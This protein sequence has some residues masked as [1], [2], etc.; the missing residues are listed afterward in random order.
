[1]EETNGFQICRFL[2]YQG[3]VTQQ[4]RLSPTAA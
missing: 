1:M 4:E 3:F 2:T